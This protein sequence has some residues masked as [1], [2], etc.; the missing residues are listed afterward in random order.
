[1]MDNLGLDTVPLSRRES[2]S[3]T[4]D[5]EKQTP[6]ADAEVSRKS[7]KFTY[8]SLSI[9]FLMQIIVLQKQKKHDKVSR[10]ESDAS[11]KDRKKD[12]S[13]TRLGVLRVLFF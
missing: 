10:R 3:D 13:A 1:M 2:K 11:D 12:K 9:L 4:K 6:A 8:F 7:S 5:N